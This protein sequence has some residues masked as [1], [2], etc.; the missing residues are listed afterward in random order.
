MVDKPPPPPSSHN[1]PLDQKFDNFQ[2]QF[3]SVINTQQPQNPDNMRLDNSINQHMHLDINQQTYNPH[4]DVDVPDDD[5]NNNPPQPV[6]PP[7]PLVNNYT[8]I[9]SGLDLT[10]LIPNL[11]AIL[12]N[13]PK[14]P[15]N[16]PQLPNNLQLPDFN[17]QALNSAQSANTIQQ[18][19][20]TSNIPLS[21][22]QQ[23]S[24][25]NNND[26]DEMD[27]TNDDITHSNDVSWSENVEDWNNQKHHNQ[28][29]QQKHS[30]H[31]PQHYPPDNQQQD[32][33]INLMDEEEDDEQRWKHR[34]G[35]VVVSL[36]YFCSQGEA[37]CEIYQ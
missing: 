2:H 22:T 31:K 35:W 26:D 1:E 20:M 3:D 29:Y 13:A 33:V 23:Q 37:S 19:Q 5:D 17:P 7:K 27:L 32:E 36:V 30:Q 11:A 9:L 4:D 12:Q 15:T 16:S 21:H 6:P 10:N 14:Q 18:Q 28:H 8:S 34:H 24:N 25:N